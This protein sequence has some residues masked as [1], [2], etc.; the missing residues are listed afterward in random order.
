[1]KTT[2]HKSLFSLGPPVLLLLALLTFSSTVFAHRIDE[3]L[4]A[5]LVVIE[6][7]RVR[8]LINITPGVAVADQVIALTDSDHDGIISTN[9][10]A[11]YC[12]SLNRELLVRLDH[13]DLKLKLTAS[14]FPGCDELRT[15]WGFIQ[16]E[17]SAWPGRLSAGAHTLTIENRHFSSA[18]VYLVNAAQP[19]SPAIQVTKQIRN[20]NQSVG[21]IQFTFRPRP[22]SFRALAFFA[23]LLM[24][25][26]SV[27]TA[28]HHNKS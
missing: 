4:Q 2:L 25:V 7:D 13:R 6:P 9:E 15:G 1:M 5:T 24:L 3:Y 12:E 22:N 17:F 27:S 20:E 18:S 14:Y 8:L 26:V 11:A 28:A 10:A 23:L 19:A 16:M 21:K